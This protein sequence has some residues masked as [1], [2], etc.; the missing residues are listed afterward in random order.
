VVAIAQDERGVTV[1]AADGTNFT[2]RYAITTQSLGVLKEG[3]VRFTPELPPE[4]SRAIASMGMGVLD[5]CILVFDSVFWGDAD[6]ISREAVDWSGLWTTFLNYNKTL[7]MPVLVALNAGDTA[8]VLENMTD[9]EV[10]AS[11]MAVVRA[12]YGGAAPDPVQS[13]VTRW[14]ADPWARGSYSFFAVGNPKNIT[15]ECSGTAAAAAADQLQRLGARD[16]INA[17]PQK[18]P[19]FQPLCLAGDVAHKTLPP[20]ADALAAPVGRLLFAGEA[21]SSKP[22]TALGAY[23][24]GQREAQR[25]AGLLAAPVAKVAEG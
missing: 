1:T 5:K 16:E 18:W 11:A 23:L 21:T 8:R 10:V 4:K 22:A 3:R 14:A 9:A 15:G 19:Y 13:F 7:G 17:K 12:M 24:S 20:R 6:F 25:A 2:A